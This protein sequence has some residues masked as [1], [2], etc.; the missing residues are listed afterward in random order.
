MNK[1][2]LAFFLLSG[3]L[4]VIDHWLKSW[5]SANLSGQPPRALISGVLGLTYFHNTGMA[6]GMLS[7]F[8]WSR[9]VIAGLV[10]LLLAGVAWYY[11]RLPAGG[12]FWAMR[13]PLIFIFAGGIANLIDRIYLGYV[14]DMLEF[15]FID[16]AIFN[17]AD[18]FITTGVFALFPVVIW[19]GKDAP[20]PVGNG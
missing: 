13:I 16:F 17:L 1:R 3:L 2:N 4:I 6:F 14:V 9:W 12:R 10:F 20:W 11:F 19:L 7:G 5:S 18:V 15:L 8:A